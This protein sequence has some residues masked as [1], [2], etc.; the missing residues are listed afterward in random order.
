ML[1]ILRFHVLTEIKQSLVSK[2]NKC[3]ADISS[4]YPLNF[5]TSKIQFSAQF[6]DLR[7]TV[8]IRQLWFK[9]V[10]A[11][12]CCQSGYVSGTLVTPQA[13]PKMFLKMSPIEH[14][15]RLIFL[16]FG[17]FILCLKR[18]LLLETIFFVKKVFLCQNCH[19]LLNLR[20]FM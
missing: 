8:R 6:Y 15:L 11:Q 18:N 5:Q 7:R 14:Q 19:S 20:H 16:Q 13:G 1:V 3:V 2:E 9:D 10:N 4:I 17:T 12:I